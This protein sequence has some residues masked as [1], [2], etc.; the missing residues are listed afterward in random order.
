MFSILISNSLVRGKPNGHISLEL[1]KAIWP[2]AISFES[3][4]YKTLDEFIKVDMN[5]HVKSKV[6]D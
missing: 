1:K 5:I 6:T 2:L 3:H 4:E